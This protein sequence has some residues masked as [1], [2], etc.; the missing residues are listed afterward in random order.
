LAKAEQGTSSPK[1]AAWLVI[2][3]V[4]LMGTWGYQPEPGS[5]KAADKGVN[6]VNLELDFDFAVRRH[7]ASIKKR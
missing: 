4:H 5:L 1:L 7:A 2:E 3:G 6:V